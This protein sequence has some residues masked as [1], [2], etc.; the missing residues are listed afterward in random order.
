MDG[1]LVWGKKHPAFTNWLPENLSNEPISRMLPSGSIKNET[2][3][4]FSWLT[5]H[6]GGAA[7]ITPPPSQNF[8]RK[9]FQPE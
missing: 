9:S 3:G 2:D 6:M 4:E 7:S 1:K 5:W 8:V